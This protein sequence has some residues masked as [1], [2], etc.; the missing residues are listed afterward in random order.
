MRGGLGVGRAVTGWGQRP[1]GVMVCLAGAGV[2][3]GGGARYGVDVVL[4]SLWVSGRGY[5]GMGF[6]NDH[7]RASARG[8]QKAAKRR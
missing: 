5:G 2:L 7:S 3:V 6:L 4:K 1:P 8:F